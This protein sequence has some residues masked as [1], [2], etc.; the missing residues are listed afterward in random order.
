MDF[1]KARQ[2]HDEFQEVRKAALDALL[3]K[4]AEIDE[5]IKVV[6]S[7]GKPAEG[8]KRGRPRKQDAE[9]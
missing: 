5:R 4:R 8:K 1:E 3:A 9:K 2:A 7:W 6:R